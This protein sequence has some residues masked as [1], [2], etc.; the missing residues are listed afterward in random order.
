MFCLENIGKAAEEGAPVSRLWIAERKLVLV[1]DG[2]DVPIVVRIAAPT[3]KS[4]REYEC[5]FRIEGEE[6]EIQQSIF[7]VDGIQAIQLATV[8]IGSTIG[9]LGEGYSWLG[10][11]GYSGFPASIDDPVEGK[12][13]QDDQINIGE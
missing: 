7:G 10:Q 1:R 12:R 8:I 11:D 6:I 3:Q 13:S 4:T 2:K 9:T 5:T